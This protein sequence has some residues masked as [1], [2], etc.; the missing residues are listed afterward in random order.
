MTAKNCDFN[1]ATDNG[2]LKYDPFVIG[3][4]EIG[5]GL[6]FSIVVGLAHANRRSHI[7]RLDKDGVV[8]LYSNLFKS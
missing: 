7:R 6:Q 1:L 8:K 5:G 3:H 4:G 2:F